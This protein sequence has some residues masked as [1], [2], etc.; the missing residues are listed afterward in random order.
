MVP[1]RFKRLYSVECPIWEYKSI[2]Q[3]G[4]YSV[5]VFILI[6]VSRQDIY[7]LPY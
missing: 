2:Q 6:V 5:S 7:S 4:D 1:Y 3:G